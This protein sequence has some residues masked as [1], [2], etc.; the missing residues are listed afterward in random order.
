MK[1]KTIIEYPEF[2]PLLALVFFG[3]VS[4]F[5]LQIGSRIDIFGA[6]RLEFLLAATL[7]VLSILYDPKIKYPPSKLSGLLAVYILLVVIQVP[8]SVDVSF[9]WN[10]FLER[11]LKFSVMAFFIARFVNSPKMIMVFLAAF[12]LSCFKMGQEGLLGNITGSMVWENQGIMRLHGSTRNY[13]HPNS[14][15]GMAL[16]TLPFIY[17]LYPLASKYL[18]IFHLVM[19]GFALNI[20]VFAGSRTAYVAFFAMVIFLFKRAKNKG[21][22]LFLAAIIALVGSFYMPEQYIERFE[23]IFTGEE[24]SGH[25]SEARTVI[26]MHAIEVFFR[27]PLGVGVSAFP[28]VRMDYFNKSPDTHNLY[29]EIAT[30][31]GI[32]G[33][34]AFL[35]LF[36][37]ALKQLDN[38]RLKFEDQ[39]SEMEKIAP[40]KLSNE[41]LD[42]HTKHFKDLKL[43]RAVA[44]SVLTYLVVRLALGVFGHDLYEI[45]WWVVLGFVFSLNK[46]NFVAEKRTS[47]L[48]ARVGFSEVSPTLA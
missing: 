45:Y 22:Y 4:A 8:L 40:D 33:L 38:L 13:A 25:S 26:V 20:I 19:I 28:I 32:Q 7:L 12:L 46:L 21:R 5:F 2:K 10:V 9:S 47:Y 35:L 15:A 43:F 36:G 23:S 1:S 6:I 27:N 16:G 17:Y 37:V 24:K 31:L 48:R 3:Y 44:S 34:V 42:A 39:L 30:N 14:F 11:F 41:D 29:L 18:K